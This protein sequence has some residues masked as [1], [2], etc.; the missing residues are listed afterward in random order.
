MP[1]QK[2][3]RTGAH[4]SH[5]RSLSS[6]IRRFWSGDEGLSAFLWLFVAVTFLFRPLEEMGV[7]SSS[8][9]MIVVGLVT[10]SGVLAMASSPH[11]R[12]VFL[13][14]AS[15]ALASSA[16]ERFSPSPGLRWLRLAVDVLW[17]GMICVVVMRHVFRAGPITWHRVE[18]ALL[19]YIVFGVMCAEA[20]MTA[21]A[22][23]P[24][25][26]MMSGGPLPPGTLS[27][28]FIYFSFTTLTTVGYGDISPVN[29]LV[30]SLANFEGLAGQIYL[31]TLI[32]QLVS[33]K[34]SDHG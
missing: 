12:V 28:T 11:L 1:R 5:Q 32:S 26:F 24:Q 16:L 4:K 23:D 21:F 22:L 20:F 19:V 3:S 8:V 2:V 13:V 7:F 10:I 25:A 17:L 6:R 18:G 30:R 33:M 9:L 14:V 29:P 31:A 27:D 15:L 34:R